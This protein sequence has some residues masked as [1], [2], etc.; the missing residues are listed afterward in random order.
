MKQH[1]YY[2]DPKEK[3]KTIKEKD[4]ILL[5]HINHNQHARFALC[6]RQTS[7]TETV[8]AARAFC[9]SAQLYGTVC[10]LPLAKHRHNTSFCANLRDI[11]FCFSDWL[12]QHPASLYHRHYLTWNLQHHC[13]NPVELIDWI[14]IVNR[15]QYVVKIKTRW[16]QCVINNV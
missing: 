10:H 15:L 3:N 16:L 13:E 4:Y 8:T 2:N 9:I 11:C 14:N 12:W 6:V 7:P 5:K 1:I